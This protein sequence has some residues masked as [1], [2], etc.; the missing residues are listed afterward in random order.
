MAEVDAGTSTEGAVVPAYLKNYTTNFVDNWAT[1][2]LGD[3]VRNSR[4]YTISVVETISPSGAFFNIPAASLQWPRFV[5]FTASGYYSNIGNYI[6]RTVA[7]NGSTVVGNSSL[8]AIYRSIAGFTVFNGVVYRFGYNSMGDLVS[9]T[10]ATFNFQSDDEFTAIMSAT[11]IL[12]FRTIT[13]GGVD[14]YKRNYLE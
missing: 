14:I 4:V 5:K 13:V 8:G 11:N 1:T 2:K 7:L 9:S 3:Y 12:E 10:G 6:D